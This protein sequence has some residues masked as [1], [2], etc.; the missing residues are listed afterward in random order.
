MIALDSLRSL[1]ELERSWDLFPRFLDQLPV[2]LE[3]SR[4]IIFIVRRLRAKFVCPFL[5]NSEE[6][7]RYTSTSARCDD[8][9]R[10]ASF[11]R[12]SSAYSSAASV[13]SSA[14]N[15][16]DVCV[17]PSLWLTKWTCA[18]RDTYDVAHPSFV[19]SSNPQSIWRACTSCR[20]E[21]RSDLRYRLRCQQ[22]SIVVYLSRSADAELHEVTMY[23]IG[24]KY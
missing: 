5:I 16:T 22:V 20:D 19:L 4:A 24:C 18:L 14:H 13:M 23:F 3:A 12:T 17:A 21:H 6:P 9:D 15:C 11:V 7:P 8:L 2:E 10:R 1:S